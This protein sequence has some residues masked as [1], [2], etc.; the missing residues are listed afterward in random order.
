MKKTIDFVNAR[1]M[2]FSK[3][4]ILI[5]LSLTTTLDIGVS[6]ILSSNNMFSFI[7]TVIGEDIH[8]RQEA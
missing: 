3:K 4:V 8:L 5:M 2:K 6:R 7:L 1:K